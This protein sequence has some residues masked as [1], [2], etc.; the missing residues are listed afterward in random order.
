MPG[1]PKGVAYLEGEP[2]VAPSRRAELFTP[3]LLDVLRSYRYPG[4]QK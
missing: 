3:A 4:L 1:K 2:L